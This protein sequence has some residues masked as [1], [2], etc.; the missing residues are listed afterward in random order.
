MRRGTQHYFTELA[1]VERIITIH[2][3]KYS[4]VKPS[5]I[6]VSSFGVHGH[7]MRTIIYFL[8]YDS[9][10]D[11]ETDLLFMPKPISRLNNKTFIVIHTCKNGLIQWI[12]T[13]KV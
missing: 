11:I 6:L 8:K 5:F 2:E 12:N 13:M 3:M 9:S 10:N 4:M 7:S 1:K